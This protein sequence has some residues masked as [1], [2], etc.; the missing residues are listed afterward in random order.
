VLAQ[1]VLASLH[2]CAVAVRH[3]QAARA[4]WSGWSADERKRA[5]AA[6]PEASSRR[7][8]EAHEVL[9]ALEALRAAGFRFEIV[10][11]VKQP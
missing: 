1:I 3:E 8:H 9:A 4:R 7:R 10:D 6:A 2:V 11:D 5:T